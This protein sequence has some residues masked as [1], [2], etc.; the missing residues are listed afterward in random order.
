ME[1]TDQNSIITN[2]K[3]QDIISQLNEEIR[4]KGRKKTRINTRNK[5]EKEKKIDK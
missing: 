2:R 5:Y 3:P 1:A 4:H